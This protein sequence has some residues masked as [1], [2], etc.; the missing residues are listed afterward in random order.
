VEDNDDRSQKQ[1]NL[2]RGPGV[3]PAEEAP[4]DGPAKNV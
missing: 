3:P 1:E 4:D 2:K